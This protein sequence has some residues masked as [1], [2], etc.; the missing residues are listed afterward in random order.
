MRKAAPRKSF[1]PR[2]LEV[3]VGEMKR[4]P[5]RPANALRTAPHVQFRL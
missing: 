4:F 2:A 1:I 3:F 5:P